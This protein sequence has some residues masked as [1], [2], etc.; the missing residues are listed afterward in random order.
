MLT[1]PPFSTNLSQQTSLPAAPTAVRRNLS[2]NSAEKPTLRRPS[3]RGG[4]HRRIQVSV[5]AIVLDHHFFVDV[6]F[7]K[8]TITASQTPN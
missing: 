4:V 3:T 8:Q 1:N 6:F 5:R 7:V 2:R